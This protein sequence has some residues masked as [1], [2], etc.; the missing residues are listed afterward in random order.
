[1]PVRSD[2]VGAELASRVTAVTTRRVL[3]YAAG[4]NASGRVH[5]EGEFADVGATVSS[6]LG[7]KSS[8]RTLPGRVIEL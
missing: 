2:A 8:G 4:R 1:M 6:W 3:A 7:G 5:E